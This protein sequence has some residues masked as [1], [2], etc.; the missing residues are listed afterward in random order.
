MVAARFSESEIL[1]RSEVA[2]GADRQADEIMEALFGAI[3]KVLT[4]E[5]VGIGIGMPGFMDTTSW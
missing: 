1:D 3:D 4:S 2:T 5:V